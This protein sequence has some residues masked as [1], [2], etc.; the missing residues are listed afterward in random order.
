[1]RPR[2]QSEAIGT[3]LLVGIAVIVVGGLLVTGSGVVDDA[4]RRGPS[5]AVS[6]AANGTTLAVTHESGDAVT[7]DEVVAVLT[8]DDGTVRRI[9]LS[10][11]DAPGDGDG[12]LTSGET[13]ATGY[14]PPSTSFSL[15]LVHEPSEL[16]IAE[17]ALT[18]DLVG[19]DFSS[20]GGDAGNTTI[21]GGSTEGTTTV[22]DGGRTVEITGNQWAQSSATYTVTPD[23]EL[24][25][26]FEST[27]TCEIHAIGFANRQNQDRMVYV[28]G[29][30]GWGTN[31]TTFGEP[32]Y[33]A[34][35]GPVRY[36]VPIGQRYDDTGQLSG[37]SLTAKLTFTNDCDAGGSGSVNSRFSNVRVYESA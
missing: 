17:R 37:G 16:V 4:Q 20:S 28:S 33:R 1:M 26:T 23:T 24:S 25:F 15:R 5:A 11:F 6:T 2:A 13:F 7:A 29:T 27:D 3:I 12:R 31:V 36:T 14:S 30:Q 19:L 10:D 22:T 35:D 21:N 9:R 34:G 18:V 32:F 8:G